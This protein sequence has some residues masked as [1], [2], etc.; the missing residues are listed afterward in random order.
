M[1]S[2]WLCGKE[3]SPKR[4]GKNPKSYPIGALIMNNLYY[5]E[6]LLI[7]ITLKDP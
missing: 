2:S 3:T 4:V 7:I 1:G 5:F 6:G